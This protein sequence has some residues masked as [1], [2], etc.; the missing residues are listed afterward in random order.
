M[1]NSEENVFNYR[2]SAGEQEEI[3]KIREKYVEHERTED[4]MEQLRRLDKSVTTKGR[5]AALTVGILST[6]ILGGGMSLTLEGAK[7]WFL[8]GVVIGV[9]GMIGAIMAYPLYAF[10]TKREREK[11]APEIIKLTDELLK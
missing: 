6:L 2:Y 4:K 1:K 5:A 7:E 3:N 11:I 10:I 9:L 8:L